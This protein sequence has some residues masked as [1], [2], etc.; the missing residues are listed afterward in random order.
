MGAIALSPW[1]DPARLVSFVLVEVSS[2]KI[3]CAM[4]VEEPLA[5]ADPE[6]TGQ[7][8]AGTA[9]LPE[10]FPLWLSPS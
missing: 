5:A 6:I 1:R 7:S 8:A 4:L 2:I 3:N 9:R 10:G